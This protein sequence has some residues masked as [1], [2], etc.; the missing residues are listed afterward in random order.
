MLSNG[1]IEQEINQGI[2]RVD[3]MFDN[4]ADVAF[5][6]DVS[7]RLKLKSPH[8]PIECKN[9]S[10]DLDSPEYDQLSGR[11]NPD[12]QMG[13]LVVR[14]ID[15][16]T[17]A[18]NHVQAKW[19]KRELLITLDDN[20]ILSLHKARFTGRPSEVDALLWGK[21]RQVSLNSAK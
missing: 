13:L 5:F 2:H 20:D 11:L 3:I 4:F 12:I 7:T 14:K 9:Y 21:V 15:N 18:L 16:P 6:A 8:V 19:K 17:K 1:Q 10:Y